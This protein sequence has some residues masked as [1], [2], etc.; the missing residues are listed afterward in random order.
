MHGDKDKHI[1]YPQACSQEKES[2][3]N[4]GLC[5]KGGITNLLSPSVFARREVITLLL[6]PRRITRNGG[7][8]I[9]VITRLV[10]QREC[11]NKYVITRSVCKRGGDN[12]RQAC[13]QGGVITNLLSPS[14]LAKRNVITNMLPFSLRTSLA[15]TILI[16]PPVCTKLVGFNKVQS[17]L[18][19][20]PVRLLRARVRARPPQ[21]PV[22]SQ[23]W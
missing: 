1:F 9:Y 6:P 8:N 18:G 22:I 7:D 2:D 16:S 17:R 5:A 11:D 12:Y 19:S 4:L 21:V 13:V 15:I 10:R 14:R 20:Y 23:I 3:N